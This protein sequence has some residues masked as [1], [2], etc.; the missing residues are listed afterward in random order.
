M[1]SRGVRPQP[2]SLDEL[3]GWMVNARRQLDL[4]ADPIE[5]AT[6]H[7]IIDDLLDMRLEWGSNEQ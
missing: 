2:D 6:I 4:A 1:R 7:Q 3:R 5:A